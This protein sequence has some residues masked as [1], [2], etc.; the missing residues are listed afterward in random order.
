M[1]LYAPRFL[2]ALFALCDVFFFFPDV[3]NFF[4]S[5][6]L[7]LIILISDYSRFSLLSVRTSLHFPRAAGRNGQE[8]DGGA[9]KNPQ[10]AP[11]WA[12]LDYNSVHIQAQALKMSRMDSTGHH[13]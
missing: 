12:D 4:S 9:L 6:L 11:R 7:V 2:C 5:P 3:L 8:L 13:S 10:E 1:S